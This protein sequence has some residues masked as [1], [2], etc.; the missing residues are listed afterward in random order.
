MPYFS[1]VV[2]FFQTSLDTVIR[3]AFIGLKTLEA[4]HLE[5]TICASNFPIGL[6]QMAY[7]RHA[8]LFSLYILYHTAAAWVTPGN[9]SPVNSS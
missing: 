7:H 3:E 1:P 4:V 9:F 5:R 8:A 2:S 6:K